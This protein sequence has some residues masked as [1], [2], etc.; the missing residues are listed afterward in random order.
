MNYKTFNLLYRRGI[1]NAF[2]IKTMG[3]LKQCLEQYEIIHKQNDDIL[4]IKKV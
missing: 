2:N 1:F 4:F 3:D